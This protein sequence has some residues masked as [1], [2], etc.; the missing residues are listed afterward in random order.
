[1]GRGGSLAAVGSPDE[2]WRRL[3]SKSALCSLL[4]IPRVMAKHPSHL[5]LPLVKYSAMIAAIAEA[6]RVDEG[7]GCGY[8]RG[9]ARW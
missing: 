1:M 7:R 8:R 4:L 6:R 5:R 9:N 2:A 3:R